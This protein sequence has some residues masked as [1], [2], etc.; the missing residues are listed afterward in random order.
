LDA[1]NGCRPHALAYVLN[2]L[3]TVLK[4]LPDQTG[5]EPQFPAP[6]LFR[7]VF[8]LLSVFIGNL[9]AHSG[10]QLIAT[11]EKASHTILIKSPARQHC[12]IKHLSNQ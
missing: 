3:T 4:L 10:Q 6:L 7:S 9:S 8:L 11:I 5:E 2:S 12:Q 1:G